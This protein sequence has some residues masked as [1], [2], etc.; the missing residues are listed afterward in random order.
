[1]R[2]VI[3]GFTRATDV[4]QKLFSYDSPR[5]GVQENTVSFGI[6]GY[7]VDAKPV[8]VS[9]R[10]NFPLSPMLPEVNSGSNVV[11]WGFMVIKDRHELD[12]VNKDPIA[13]KYVRRYLCGR[14]L[15][16]GIDR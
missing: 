4:R 10:H 3:E 6:N 7:L 15:I 9:A 11:D 5:G 16:N 1:M 2:R 14:E 8:E 13:A 12:E